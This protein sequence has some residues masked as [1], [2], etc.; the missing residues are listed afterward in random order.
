MTGVLISIEIELRL[1][2]RDPAAAAAVVLLPLIL[3]MIN[4]DSSLGIDVVAP[5]LFAFVLGTVAVAGLPQG[6]AEYREQG[7]FRRLALTEM[8]TST[9]LAVQ[10]LVCLVMTV[11]TSGLLAVVAAV[12]FGLEAPSAPLNLLVG[13]VLGGSALF[14]LAFA[15]AGAAPSARSATGLAMGLYFPMLF[16]SGAAYPRD[17]LPEL[18][19]H[20][21]DVLPLTWA[22]E[23]FSAAWSGPTVAIGPVVALAIWTVLGTVAALRLFR[24]S[25]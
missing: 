4:G 20:V 14:S 22:V 10:A 17:R 18:A 24:W 6:L 11:L 15:I 19:Q 3:L 21:G 7:V 1:W 5:A 25:T 8:R 23:A 16:L 13:L 12:G 9:A 2:L